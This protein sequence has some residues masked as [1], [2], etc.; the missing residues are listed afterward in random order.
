MPYFILELYVTTGAAENDGTMPG[1]FMTSKMMTA[2]K[3]VGKTS[4]KKNKK[5]KQQMSQRSSRM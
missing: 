2:T 1:T 5:L 4:L 3:H